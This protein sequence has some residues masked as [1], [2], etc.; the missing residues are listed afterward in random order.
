MV[1]TIFLG[2]LLGLTLGISV[3]TELFSRIGMEPKTYMLILTAMLL[4]IMLLNR[5]IAILASGILLSLA[6]LQPDQVLLEHGFDKDML[7]ASLLVMLL[8]PVVYRV[9]Y[10]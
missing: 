5:G 2:L 6:V 10:S 8:Y 7:M 9:M 4:A 3:A 1:K